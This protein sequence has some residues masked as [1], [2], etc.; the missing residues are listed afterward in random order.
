MQ[1]W[2]WYEAETRRRGEFIYNLEFRQGR[3]ED[4]SSLVWTGE[5]EC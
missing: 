3:G 1:K 4:G 5:E 2:E